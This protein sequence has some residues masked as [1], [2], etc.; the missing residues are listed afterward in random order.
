MQISYSHHGNRLIFRRRADGIQ[1]LGLFGKALVPHKDLEGGSILQVQLVPAESSCH[2]GAGRISSLP[3]ERMELISIV[4]DERCHGDLVV[5][6]LKDPL[7]GILAEVNYFLS[8]RSPTI[9]TWVRVRNDGPASVELHQVRSAILHNLAAGGYRPWHEKTC[10]YLCYDRGSG[11]G[12]WRRFGR[13]QPIRGSSWST[14]D[15]LPMGILEDMETETA[16]YW[17][18]EHSHIWDWAIGEG[19]NSHLSLWAS[20]HTPHQDGWRVEL[21]PGSAFKTVSV[22]FGLV[23]G[24]SI[25]A[26]KALSVYWRQISR[27]SHHL[28]AGYG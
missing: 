26:W 2:S 22:V 28:M 15:A 4:E 13:R 6:I 27:T 9:R 14:P 7:T 23:P 3:A 17:Q 25:Q 16:W 8:L 20:D 24:G 11:G 12:R 19:Q 5:I 21:Q 10:L 1:L 18:I